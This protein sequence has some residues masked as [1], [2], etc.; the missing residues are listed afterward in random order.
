MPQVLYPHTVGCQ[1]NVLDSELVV[2]GLLQAGYELVDSRARP[3]RSCSTRA[4]SGSMPKTRST[5]P[6]A[7]CRH[8]KEQRP[9]DDHRRPGLHGAEGPGADLP[10]CAARRPGRRAGPARPACRS[11]WSEVRRRQREPQLEVSL[12]RTSGSRGAGRAELRPLRPA[13]GRRCAARAVPGDGAD[14]VR[15]RQVLHLLHRAP[16]PRAGAEPPGRGD[17]GRSPPPGRP[18]LPGSHAAGPDRQQLPA[19]ASGGRTRAAV[20]PAGR[21]CTTSTGLRRLQV[22]HQ[23]SAAHDRRSARRRSAT[24]PRS[25]PICTCRPRA[26]RTSVLKRMKRGYTV[27]HY[28]EMLERIR[29]IVPARGGH[30]RLH[31]RLLRRDGGRFPADGRPGARGRGSRTASSSSTAPG[32]ARKAAELYADDVPEEVKRRRNNELLAMQNADQP[33]GQ[34]AAARPDGGGPGRRAEQGGEERAVGQ[35]SVPAQGDAASAQDAATTAQSRRPDGWRP[36]RWFL[37]PGRAHRSRLAAG[38][39]RAVE[40]VHALARCVTL[41]RDG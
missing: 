29:Q 26:A 9:G 19:T 18:G 25:R 6:W 11:S 31:R 37:W 4:A 41:E 40:R 15:L 12:D 13:A 36:N 16:G 35:A 21:G 14:H 30:Q 20:R 39:D 17:R 24:C 32:R 34:P 22:R 1:M 5:A 23:L 2:A 27:E 33:G 8:V 7:G 3:T 38:G 10:P 28:R